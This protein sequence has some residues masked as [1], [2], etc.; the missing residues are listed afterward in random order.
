M[1]AQGHG[2]YVSIGLEALIHH[3]DS[4]F[5]FLPITFVVIQ[6]V[7]TSIK[8]NR[9]HLT[10]LKCM[11]LSCYLFIR[12]V[13]LY[14]F[15]VCSGNQYAS[16]YWFVRANSL[17][18]DNEKTQGVLCA[19]F[20]IHNKSFSPHLQ[21]FTKRANSSVCD[22]KL[23]AHVEYFDP[24]LVWSL[25]YVCFSA[26]AEHALGV[27]YNCCFPVKSSAD[28]TLILWFTDMPAKT[29]IFCQL[30]WQLPCM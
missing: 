12:V 25:L 29:K 20:H 11:F 15:F 5:W 2:V 21:N 8:W 4:F 14:F 24:D 19:C 1:T 7:E 16:A 18:S 30:L 13:F 28:V 9:K 3:F 17:F 10:S 22:L 6:V 26:S 23:E 27:L